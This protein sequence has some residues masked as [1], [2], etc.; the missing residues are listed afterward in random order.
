MRKKIYLNSLLTRSWK[1]FMTVF[2]CT[3]VR[4]FCNEMNN[5]KKKNYKLKSDEIKKF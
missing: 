3:F 1:A 4:L 2:E 5:K